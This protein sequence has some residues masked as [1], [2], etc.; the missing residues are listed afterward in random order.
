MG[1]TAVAL[2]AI[3]GIVWLSRVRAARRFNAALDAYAEREIERERRRN[4]P[5]RVRGGF[6]L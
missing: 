4:G 5:Q 2:T 3:L 1:A 6:D